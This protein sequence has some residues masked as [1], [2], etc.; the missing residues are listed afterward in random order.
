[1]KLTIEGT[2]DEIQKVLQAIGSG[3]EQELYLDGASLVKEINAGIKG[4]K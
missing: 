3:K 1:M 4:S 2:S